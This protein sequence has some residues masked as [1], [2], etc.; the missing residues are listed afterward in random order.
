MMMPFFELIRVALGVQ[1]FLSRSLLERDWGELY[2]LA[3]KQ[4]L[5]GICFTGLQ[6]LG[7]DADDGF[8]KIGMS[9]MQYLDWMAD[10]ATLHEK[11]EV[12]NRRCVELQDKLS[13]SGMRSSI[14]KGQGIARYYQCDGEDMSLFR[15]SG[16]IDVY[17]DCGRKKG[18]EFAHSIGQDVVEWDYKHLHLNLFDD[19][20]VEVHYRAQVLLNPFKNQRLQKFFKLHEAELLGEPVTL[21][22]GSVITAPVGWFNVFYIILHLYHHLFGEGIGLRQLMDLYF[23]L[24]NTELTEDE[25]SELKSSVEEFGMSKFC[26]ALMWTLSEA[27]GPIGNNELWAADEK[28]GRF[29]LDEALRCGNFGKNDDRYNL[30]GTGKAARFWTIVRKNTHLLV[31]YPGDALAAP[32]YFVWHFFWKRLNINR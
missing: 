24:K 12:M 23:V 5:V 17:V 28:E 3:E 1:T 25:K 32:L 7:A 2:K 14:L 30:S 26:A 4:S 18:V 27:F 22:D 11:N 16:D 6:Y 8:E 9:E 20:P 21:C 15:Q 29:I 10:A 19:T 31:H 13:E